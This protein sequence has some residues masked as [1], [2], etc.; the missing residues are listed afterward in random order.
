[1]RSA[2]RVLGV[3]LLVGVLGVLGVATP[4]QGAAAAPFTIVAAQTAANAEQNFNGMSKGQLVITVPVGAMVQITFKNNGTLPHSLQIIP[5]TSPL[6]ATAL[7]APAFPGAQIKN[8]QAG[9]NKGQTATAQFT[10]TKPGKYL[11]ICGF[12]GHALLGMYANFIVAD[13]PAAKPSMTVNK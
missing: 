3:A 2:Q 6:P 5:P 7:S 12:P 11:M 10:A 9:I 1:M 4:G 13:S 8:P